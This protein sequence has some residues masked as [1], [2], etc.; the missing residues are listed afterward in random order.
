MQLTEQY[1]AVQPH[2]QCTRLPEATDEMPP[3]WQLLLF[4]LTSGLETLSLESKENSTLTTVDLSLAINY[5]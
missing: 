5:T 4:I 1:H 2:V 3:A